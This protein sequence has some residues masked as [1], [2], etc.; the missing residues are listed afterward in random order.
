MVWTCAYQELHPAALSASPP[1][2]AELP[3]HDHAEAWADGGNISEGRAIQC[4]QSQRTTRCGSCNTC[5][6]YRWSGWAGKRGEA[7]CGATLIPVMQPADLGNGHQR[8]TA[9]LA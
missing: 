1:S 9:V 3:V 6:R 4:W 8:D 2:S 5:V 7:L